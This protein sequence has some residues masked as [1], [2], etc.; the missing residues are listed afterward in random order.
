MRCDVSS[1]SSSNVYF[2][3]YE[4]ISI[5]LP[6]FSD[7]LF[8]PMNCPH[9]A[10]PA[11]ISVGTLLSSRAGALYGTSLDGQGAD[12]DHKGRDFKGEDEIERV[13]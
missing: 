5:F 9:H 11:R 1:N 10:P 7:I 13:D 12:G 3:Y 4:E 2:V 6:L 8:K